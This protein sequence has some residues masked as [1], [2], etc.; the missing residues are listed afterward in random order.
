MQDVGDWLRALRDRHG[1]SQSQLAYRASTSQQ[2]ISRIEAGQTS[3]SVALLERLAAA[4]GEELQ[5]SSEPRGVPFE[6]RQLIE[7]A[8][9]SIEQRLER[10]FGWNHFASELAIAGAKARGELNQAV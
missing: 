6:D 7:S 10:S 3:P 4:C 8:R 5:I 1:L 2:A 9:E